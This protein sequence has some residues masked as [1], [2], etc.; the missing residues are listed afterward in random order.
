MF[1]EWHRLIRRPGRVVATSIPDARKRETFLQSYTQGVERASHLTDE[2]KAQIIERNRRASWYDPD[3]LRTWWQEHGG[4]V[5]IRPLCESDP[6]AD[7]RFDL[8]VTLD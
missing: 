2:T 7:H 6:N 4:E 1:R 3:V 8:I 5:E